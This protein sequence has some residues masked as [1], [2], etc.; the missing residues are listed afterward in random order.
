MVSIAHNDGPRRTE[1]FSRKGTEKSFSK[2]KPKVTFWVKQII[3]TYKKII[4]AYVKKGRSA[5]RC[6]KRHRNSERTNERV[7]VIEQTLTAS[8]SS[9]VTLSLDLIASEVGSDVTEASVSDC[10]SVE[11]KKSMLMLNDASWWLGKT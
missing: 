9:C 4:I 6:W 1:D 3:E 11:E 10:L 7:K 2:A 5:E 8:M